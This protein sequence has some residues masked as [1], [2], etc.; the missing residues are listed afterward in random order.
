MKS[1]SLAASLAFVATVLAV[2]PSPGQIRNLVTFGDSYTDVVSTGDG[3]V[4]WPVFAAADGHFDLFPFARSGATC[5]NNLTAEPFPSLFESQL[6]LFFAEKANGSLKLNTEETIV[7]LWI[8]TNDVGRTALLTGQHAPGV[9]LVDVVDCAINWVS[10][11]FTNGFRNFLF[12]N[13]IP[14]D[15]TILYSANSYPNRYW[16]HPRNTTEWNVFMGELVATGNELQRLKLAALAP[17]LKGAH[18]GIFDSH[19]LFS[20]MII[21]PQLY[22]NGTAPLNVTGAVRSCVFEVNESTTDTGDCTIATGT[23]IDSFVWFDELHPSVQT[24]RIVAREVTA[25]IQRQSDRWTTWLV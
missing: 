25:A 7:T 6:P 10:V 2:G 21:H 24:D 16:T 15:K 11:M 5:S 1:K 13:M 3:G 22:L 4:A 20:D 14:L 18:L 9:T 8:G 23:D 19:A 12:Q 17:S